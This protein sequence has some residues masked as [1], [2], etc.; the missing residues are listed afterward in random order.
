MT[1]SRQDFLGWMSLIMGE[2]SK[3][4]EPREDTNIAATAPK[5]PKAPVATDSTPSTC[6]FIAEG[7][8]SIFKSPSYGFSYLNSFLKLF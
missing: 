1:G 3:D 8:S 5:Q 7:S 2:D 4:D 6:G